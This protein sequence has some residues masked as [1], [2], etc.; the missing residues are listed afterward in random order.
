ML[1]LGAVYVNS[2]TDVSYSLL[3][4]ILYLHVVSYKK[5]DS[6]PYFAHLHPANSAETYLRINIPC[7]PRDKSRHRLTYLTSPFFR[8][9]RLNRHDF[10]PAERKLDRHGSSSPKSVSSSPNHLQAS[11][12]RRQRRRHDPNMQT[13]RGTTSETS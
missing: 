2:S 3:A 6:Y 10:K 8:K 13:D 5:R 9:H 4:H 1:L 7:T 11:S 12:S